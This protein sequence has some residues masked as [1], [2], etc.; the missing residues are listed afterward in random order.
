[1]LSSLVKCDCHVCSA[2][3][4]GIMLGSILSAAIVPDVQSS[5]RIP[6]MV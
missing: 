1:M 2:N 4:V 3:P 6:L 5:Y